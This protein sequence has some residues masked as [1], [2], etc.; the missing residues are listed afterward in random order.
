MVSHPDRLK[1]IVS[2]ISDGNMSFL[3]GDEADVVA[4]RTKFIES[5]GIKPELVSI[6]QLEHGDK[7]HYVDKSLG[8][9]LNKSA[10][11]A[12]TADAIATD[13]KGLGL[14]LIVAD[15]IPA[16]LYDTQNAALAI[17]HAG[18]KGVEQDILTKT[19][20]WMNEKFGS[21]IS[22]MKLI[23]GPSIAKESYVFDDTK[24]IDVAFWGDFL[25]LGADKKYHMDVAGKFCSQAKLAGLTDPQVAMSKIDTFADRHYFSHRRSTAENKPEGRF[26]LL[27]Y[28]D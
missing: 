19:I 12:V 28:I 1:A 14:M 5:A 25:S 10:A 24:E 22:D 6:I 13:R 17:I 18:R 8:N 2:E 7:I 11:A 3:W 9:A 26:A 4:N 21:A 23:G 27:A 15:C 16:V 20:A